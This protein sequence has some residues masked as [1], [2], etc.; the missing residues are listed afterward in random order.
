ML[1]M[2]VG[3]DK[4]DCIANYLPSRAHLMRLPVVRDLWGNPAFTPHQQSHLD[5]P[6]D[7]GEY[8]YGLI[9]DVYGGAE[10]YLLG[11]GVTPEEL[12]CVRDRLVG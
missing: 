9:N 6:Y 10:N 1:L 4:Y 12:A 11:A 7:C 3:V 2:L 8:I 5:A